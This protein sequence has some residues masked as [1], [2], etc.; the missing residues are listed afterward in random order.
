[1]LRSCWSN[2]V[3]ERVWLSGDCFSMDV[4]DG[5]KICVCLNRERGGLYKE[6]EKR[7]GIARGG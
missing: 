1:M 3:C 5:K 2:D 4:Y 7:G 6:K